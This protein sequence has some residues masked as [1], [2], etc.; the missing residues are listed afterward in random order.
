[1]DG[2]EAHHVRNQGH[3]V[4]DWLTS[5]DE[6]TQYFCDDC[7]L[8]MMVVETSR[9]VNADPELVK[10]TQDAFEKVYY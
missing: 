8:L 1:M 3:A 10:R 6:G 4:W 9:K 5:I 2:H 7:Q